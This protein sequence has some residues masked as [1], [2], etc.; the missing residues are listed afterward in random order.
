MLSTIL[1]KAC[2]GKVTKEKLKSVKTDFSLFIH[3]PSFSERPAFAPPNISFDRAKGYVSSH[4][5]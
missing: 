3:H 4:E 2:R 5:T 1:T